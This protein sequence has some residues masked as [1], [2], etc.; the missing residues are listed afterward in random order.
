SQPDAVSVQETLEKALFVLLQQHTPVTG[1]GRTDTGVH[2]TRYYAHFD[3]D[4]IEDRNVLIYKLNSVLP[5]DIAV[6][7]VFKVPEESHARFDALSRSYKYY[8]IQHKNPF[9]AERSHR[10]EERRVGKEWS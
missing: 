4:E 6:F 8:V 7:D 5:E 10:S 3:A 9:L 2:A 1:A